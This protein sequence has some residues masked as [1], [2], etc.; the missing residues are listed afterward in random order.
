[1]IMFRIV[2]TVSLNRFKFYAEIHPSRTTRADG[3][4]GRVQMNVFEYL[5]I[6]GQRLANKDMLRPINKQRYSKSR[7]DVIEE[8]KRK[9][10]DEMNANALDN[11]VANRRKLHQRGLGLF[12]KLVVEERRVTCNCEN[13]RRYGK[14]EDSELLGFIC[15]EEI[16][17]PKQNHAIDF[18]ACKEGYSKLSPKILE[19][20]LDLVGSENVCIHPPQQDPSSVAQDL[21]IA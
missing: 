3:K 11:V 18:N 6:H 12:H 8:S 4:G 10:I 9:K 17:Y 1:M 15:L 13:F 5:F 21:N 14:C 20:V 16:G 7:Q 19:K 2:F